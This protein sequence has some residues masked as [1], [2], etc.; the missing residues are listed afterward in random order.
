MFDWLKNFADWIIYTV[1][2]IAEGSKLGDTL[3]FFVYDTIKIIIL[4][5]NFVSLVG[6][7]AR[8]L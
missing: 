6:G 5:L 2:Q 7:R 8:V 4:L 1:F 3:N